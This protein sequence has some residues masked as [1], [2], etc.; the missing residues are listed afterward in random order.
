[1]SDDLLKM[2]GGDDGSTK[3][4]KCGKKLVK[5]ITVRNSPRT[6]TYYYC[7]ACSLKVMN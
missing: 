3:C 7:G 4:K 6:N 5:P 2:L 1:M